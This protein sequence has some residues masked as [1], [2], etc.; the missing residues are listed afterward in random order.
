[1]KTL[2]TLKAICLCL[3]FSTALQAQ[4]LDS[5]E[6]SE[7]DRGNVFDVT[8]TGSEDTWQFNP[9]SYFYINFSGIGVTLQD[10]YG[11]VAANTVEGVVEV[12]NDA[13]Q[14]PRNLTMGYYN[15][16]EWSESTLEYVFEVYE[17]TIVGISPTMLNR[18]E[19]TPIQITGQHTN[20]KGPNDG[21]SV[22]VRFENEDDIT[23]TNT[24]L[25]SP[26]LLSAN[27]IVNEDAALGPQIIYV[28]YGLN[29]PGGGERTDVLEAS[30]EPG[31]PDF[32]GI[33]IISGV[34]NEWVSQFDQVAVY[35]NPFSS[36]F[37]IDYQ[38]KEAAEVNIELFD[39]SGKKVA[40]I[41]NANQTA[42]NHHFD[43][44]IEEGSLEAGIYILNL[45]ADGTTY[46]KT[47][48]SIK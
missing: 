30:G 4:Q 11:I 29:G 27:V 26:T 2:I 34:N 47:V 5:I 1:M 24:N 23:I 19:S 17:S 37:A 22:T 40:Q 20:W 13:P 35:P 25:E 44:Q 48:V 6:P 31:E 8:I 7:S 16:Y 45:S 41:L 15:G 3:L 28:D 38:L 33:A 10:G 18:G 21:G 32:V 9:Y 46:S 39:L 43:Y 14:G 42:G 36:E 12:M